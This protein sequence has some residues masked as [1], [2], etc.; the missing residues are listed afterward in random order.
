MYRNWANNVQPMIRLS[1]AVTIAYVPLQQKQIAKAW[2][3]GSFLSLNGP[4]RINPDFKNEN[5][6]FVFSQ[7]FHLCNYI[8]MIHFFYLL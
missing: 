6:Q 2:D 3:S 8:S 5:I 4:K 1:T 7:L